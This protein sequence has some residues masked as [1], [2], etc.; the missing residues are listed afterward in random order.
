MTS[1]RFVGLTPAGDPARVEAAL[2]HALAL[3]SHDPLTHY[4]RGVWHSQHG[5]LDLA[6]EDAL[7]AVQTAQR[8][9]DPLAPLVAE[10]VA[11]GLGIDVGDP[12]VT[13]QRRAAAESVFA[14]PGNLGPVATGYLGDTLLDDGFVDA[15]VTVG[16]GP[17]RVAPVVQLAHGRPGDG[18]CG[19]LSRR[20][21]FRSP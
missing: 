7:L 21:P 6:D 8:S 19:S 18:V 5:Q 2:E 1:R 17:G 15:Q 12:A 14:D 11:G 10:V 16:V 20:G 13:A 3:D 4:L 9:R